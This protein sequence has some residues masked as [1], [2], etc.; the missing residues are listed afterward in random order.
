MW[1]IPP[2]STLT[3]TGINTKKT[4]ITFGYFPVDR[5]PRRRLHRLLV[6]RRHLPLLPQRLQ[7]LRLLYPNRYS[8]ATDTHSYSYS[9]T[10]ANAKI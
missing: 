9:P 8:D 1:R 10:H 5:G 6:Q 4:F 3:R 7:P 2:R